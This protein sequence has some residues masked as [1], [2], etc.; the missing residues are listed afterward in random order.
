MGVIQALPSGG[1]REKSAEISAASSVGGG[2]G[3]AAIVSSSD[4]GNRGAAA[5]YSN[6]SMRKLFVYNLAP[7]TTSETLRVSEESML[8]V[9]GKYGP[10]DECI[11][12]YDSAGKSK[13]YAFVT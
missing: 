6:Q 3:Q 13:R 10:M 1:E 4:T 8:E 5:T 7:Y 2:S 9:F 11:V 12:V